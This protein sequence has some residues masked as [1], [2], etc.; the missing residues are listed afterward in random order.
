M[1]EFA[2]RQI[3]DVHG[4]GVLDARKQRLQL[5]S[6]RADDSIDCAGAD[7]AIGCAVAGINKSPSVPGFA[8]GA[9]GSG[10]TSRIVSAVA[11]RTSMD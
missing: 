9:T 4:S 8:T 11:L 3:L 1:F 5:L 7:T 6:A 10:G 2:K